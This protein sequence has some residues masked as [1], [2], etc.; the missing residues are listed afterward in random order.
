M[1]QLLYWLDLAGVAVF[2]VSGALEAA[3]KQ[4]DIVGFLFVAAVTGIGGGTLRDVLLDRGPVFWVHDP[5]YLWVTSTAAIVTFLIA[6]HLERRAI[7]LLWADA[8]GMALFCVLGARTALEGGA[9]PEVAVLMGTMTAT[10]GGL[11]RDVVCT[12]TP[13]LLRREIYAT[14]AASGA[15]MLVLGHE[16]GMADP[17][18]DFLGMALAFAIRGLA[19]ARGLSLPV[20]RPRVARSR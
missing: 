3:R 8:L 15:A 7:A 10:F 9:G 2:A 17:F 16:L 12:E 14:A 20:Y 6:P 1:H 4:L 11:I 13:L 18:A 19:L 5:V